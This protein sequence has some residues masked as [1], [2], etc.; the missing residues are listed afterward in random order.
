MIIE[1]GKISILIM[2]IQIMDINKILIKYLVEKQMTRVRLKKMLISKR[3]LARK[4]ENNRKGK[5]RTRS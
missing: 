1:K 4:R 5:R 2:M 3:N